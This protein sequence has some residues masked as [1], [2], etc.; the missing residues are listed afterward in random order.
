MHAAASIKSGS[1]GARTFSDAYPNADSALIAYGGVG[2]VG[3]HR[4]A[5]S[6]AVFPAVCVL[7]GRLGASRSA[8]VAAGAQVF[9]GAGLGVCH[10]CCALYR[11]RS[12]LR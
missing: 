10:R 11:G 3:W 8:W 12:T 1:G 5:G 2:A 9:A 4:T 6:G 7:S